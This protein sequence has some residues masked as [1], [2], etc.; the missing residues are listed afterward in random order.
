MSIPNEEDL[1]RLPLRAI[2]AFAARCDRQSDPCTGSGNPPPT[3]RSTNGASIAPSSSPN[4]SRGAT[5]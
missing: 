4:R 5:I 1:K 2:V 3:E